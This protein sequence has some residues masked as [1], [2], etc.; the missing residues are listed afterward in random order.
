MDVL[1]RSTCLASE[2]FSNL[3]SRLRSHARFCVTTHNTPFLFSPS[4]VIESASSEYSHI[5]Y[6]RKCSSSF[7]GGGSHSFRFVVI[8]FLCLRNIEFTL[9]S[10]H[11][12]I[13]L[14]TINQN[15]AKGTLY[16]TYTV[17]GKQTSD[18]YTLLLQKRSKNK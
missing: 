6:S 8:H 14:K 10:V 17:W 11:D 4:H 5:V 12:N 15:Y 2:S 1:S 16:D 13:L 18:N 3:I 9:K 7:F